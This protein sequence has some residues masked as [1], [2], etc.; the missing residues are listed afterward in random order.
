MNILSDRSKAKL[1]DLFL[2]ELQDLRASCSIEY[3]RAFNERHNT[4]EGEFKAVSLEG[5]IASLNIE[6]K[7]VDYLIDKYSELEKNIL[8]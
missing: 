3:N 4:F 7:V 6:M 5:R 2:E 8:K 1:L